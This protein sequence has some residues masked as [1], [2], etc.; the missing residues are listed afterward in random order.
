V[1]QL[2]DKQGNLTFKL[3]LSDINKPADIKAPIETKDIQSGSYYQKGVDASIKGNMATLLVN[4][5]VLY[6][7]NKSYSKLCSDENYYLKIKKYIDEAYGSG[8]KVVCIAQSQKWCA[9]A[10]LASG[11]YYCVDSKGIKK[12]SSDSNV[13]SAGECKN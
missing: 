10:L 9:S 13:C 6:D 7:A 4:G 11:N 2:K 5:E 12:E 3:E 1:T 8:S